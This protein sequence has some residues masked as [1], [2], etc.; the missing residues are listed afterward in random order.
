MELNTEGIITWSAPSNIALIK[1]WGKR[2]LQLPCNPSL[3]L[4]LEKSRTQTTLSWSSLS[5]TSVN[6]SFDFYF[7]QKK[8][9]DFHP[10]IEQM[11]KS[12]IKQDPSLASVFSRYHFV[13]ESRNTF[14]HSTGIASSASAM[15]ALSL[16]FLSFIR[17]QKGETYF[18]EKQEEHHSF[19]QASSCIA[20]LGSGSASR[21]V[22][23]YASLWGKSQMDGPIFA[24]ESDEYA[25]G[26]SLHPLFKNFCDTILIVSS[27]PKA[28]SSS[29]GH[30]SI[31]THPYRDNR[32]IRAEKRAKEMF[33]IL[34]SGDLDKFIPLVE[35]EAFDLHSLM[36]SGDEPFCLMRPGTLA[37]IEK[38]QAFRQNE[39]V[40]VCFTLDAGPNV[41]LLYPKEYEKV[42]MPWVESELS[43]FCSGSEKTGKWIN[44]EVGAGP[45]YW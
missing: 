6:F 10:K 40:P 5:K 23:P 25:V 29:K 38:I 22:W 3:S 15:A 32:F 44:D 42:V 17:W 9:I 35:A 19:W 14:P 16:C 4:T 21:S 41:H 26:I 30:Q 34:T 8:Q 37:I 27:T 33:S 13:I 2:G 28:V 7:H 31:A 24:P 18:P 39:K 1:Y 36:M 43:S 20:R 12:L 11:I 45:L